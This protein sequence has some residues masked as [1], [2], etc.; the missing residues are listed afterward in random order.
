MQF[1]NKKKT[2]EEAINNDYYNKILYKVCNNNLKSVCDRDE[3]KTIVLTTLWNCIDKYNIKKNVKFSSYLYRSIQNNSRRIYKK[4]IKES[5]EKPLIDNLHSELLIDNKSF[6]EAR[7]IL[8][9][10]KDLNEELYDVLIL[11]FYYN[12]TNK[13]IGLKNGYGKEAARKKLK[14]AL[15]LCRQIVYSNVGTGT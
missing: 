15:D 9:S 4:K 3:I 8:M 6:E 2:F 5:R 12:M 13:E 7:D 11:K 14:K 1:A 10:I